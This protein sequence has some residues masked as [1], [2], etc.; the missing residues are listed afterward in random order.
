MFSVRF[1]H[2]LLNYFLDYVEDN[3]WCEEE[4]VKTIRGCRSHY[5]NFK[6][7]SFINN[8]KSDSEI[9]IALKDRFM[10][11]GRELYIYDYYSDEALDEFFKN[12]S[13]VCTDTV[14]IKSSTYLV[15]YIAKI[16]MYA[17]KYGIKLSQNSE[18]FSVFYS[19]RDGKDYFVRIVEK[20][21][22]MVDSYGVN[23]RV[24][25]NYSIKLKEYNSIDKSK[26]QSKLF[27]DKFNAFLVSSFI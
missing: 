20:L 21:N 10:L 13:I 16:I 25:V 17:S 22:S 18:I 5:F 27:L 9:L 6:D 2:N 14:T 3:K 12:L 15:D 26:I 8:L 7:Y 19:Y 23:D 1:Y 24:L 11:N 4:I